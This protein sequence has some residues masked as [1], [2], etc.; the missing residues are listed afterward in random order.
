ME[1]KKYDFWAHALNRLV[2][3]LPDKWYLFFRFK[4]RVG[5]WPHLDHPRSF[6]EKLLWL[7]L[8]DKHS[9]F[10][11]MVDKV[12]A[13]KYVASV[14]GDKFIIP[15]LGVWDSVDE[16]D[17]ESLPN[18]FVIKVTSDSGGI[19][20]CKDKK[21]LDIDKAKEKLS[22]GW[23]KNYYVH[24]KEYPYKALKPRIIAEEYKEDESGY[25]LKDYKFFC[26]NGI[27]KVFKVDFGRFSSHHANYY[28]VN[29]KLLPFCEKD[30]PSD[31]SKIIHFP[32]N[33]SEM[34]DVAEKIAKKVNHPFVRVDLYNVN[35]AIFFGEIT[36]FPASGMG[37]FYPEEWDFK[38]G[39]YMQLPLK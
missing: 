18:Q 33:F 26:F 19:V 6:N 35:G 27:P 31:S 14:V 29:C 28:D 36:F 21:L 9:E 32:N 20:V 24:N 11:Q 15:T 39:T 3:V 13:K 5:Y 23:G 1:N 7:K 4:N 30:F 8:H 25:E 10:T 2:Y 22:K 12:E 17:W 37:A 34:I 16:I 38:L